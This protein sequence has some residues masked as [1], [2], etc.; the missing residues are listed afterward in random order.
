MEY[1]SAIKKNTVMPFA[2]RWMQL[3]TLILNEVSQKDKYHTISL[4]S[5]N[6]YMAQMN[7]PQKRKSWTWR[8]DSWLPDGG[9]ERVGCI[10]NLGFRDA[11][12][13]FWNG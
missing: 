3:E 10:G 6:K 2:A 11:D 4:I 5:R 1:Y 12:S 13:C 7:L 8:T 9:E